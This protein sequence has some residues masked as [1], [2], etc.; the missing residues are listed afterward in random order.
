MDNDTFTASTTDADG[1]SV[2]RRILL[3]G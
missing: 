3:S 2:K 1:G